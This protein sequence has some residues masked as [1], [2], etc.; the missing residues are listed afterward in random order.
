METEELN[1]LERGAMQKHLDAL[2]AK[3]FLDDAEQQLAATLSKKLAD[4]E[5]L[6]AMEKALSPSARKTF[7]RTSGEL[8]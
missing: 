3:P 8:V 1:K 4:G 2:N 7:S 6:N 5:T